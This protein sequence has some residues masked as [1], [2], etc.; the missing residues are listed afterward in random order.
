MIAPARHHLC[1]SSHTP[2]AMRPLVLALVAIW[3]LQSLQAQPVA[4]VRPPV[5]AL[6]AV[7]VPALKWQQ[8][9]EKY[10]DG[11]RSSLTERPNARG[12]VDQ[13][14][15]QRLA[16]EIYQW[17]R[18]DI[19]AAS[20]VEFM[21]PSG[22]AALN[23][24]DKGAA[25]S[26]IFGALTATVPNPNT[27]AGQPARIVGGDVYLLNANGILFGSGAQ[28]NVGALVASTLNVDNEDFLNGLTRSINGAQ[29][30]FWR[31]P[32]G[33]PATQEGSGFVEVQPGAE[34]RTPNGG[35]VFLFAEEVKQAGR[36]ETP[37]GQTVLAAGSEVYLQAP[38][39]E[40][41]YAAEHNAAVPALRG[42]LVE[43]GGE[44]GRV[45]Q[46]GEILSARGNTTLVGMAVNQ[47]GRISASTSVS[48]NGSVFLLARGKASA[49]SVAS[50]VF[51]RA[52]EGGSL[53]L[54]SS[55]RIEITPEASTATSSDSAGFTPSRIE[56]SARSISLQGAEP[57]AGS[58]GSGSG[59]GAS[60]VA[61]G[62][63][64][65]LRAET[66]PVYEVPDTPGSHALSLPK[67]DTPRF[68]ATASLSLGRGVSIDLSGTRDTEVSAGRHYVTT[69]LLGANDLK[70]APLQKDGLLY[71][72]KVTLDI[73]KDS[74]ILGSLQSYR[75]AVERSV[76]ER[77]SG[78]GSL[79]LE[80]AGLVQADAGS[81]LDL[82]G[83]R[84]RYTAAITQ[85]SQ[86]RGA[87]GLLY[88]LNEAPADQA[89]VGLSNAVYRHFGRWG[90]VRSFVLG[91]SL[92]LA[93]Y[94]E[95]QAAGS[96]RVAG[97]QL[98]LDGEMLARTLVGER[99]REGL[100][101]LAAPGRLQL[102]QAS[103]L[104]T[105]VQHT[106]LLGSSAASPATSG[107]GSWLD[108]GRLDASGFGRYALA[109][110]GDIVVE[111]ALRLAP[112]SQL[113]LFSRGAQGIRLAADVQSAGG[114]LSAQTVARPEQAGS[115]AGDIVVADGVRL[116]LAGR[117]VNQERDG[118]QPQAS[119]EGGSLRLNSGAGL[120]L[121]RDTVLDVSGGATVSGTGRV[122]AGAAG[123]I[124]LR[125]SM[126]G[127]QAQR[128]D[129]AGARLLGL[130]LNRGGSLSLRAAEVEIGGSASS[131]AE[132]GRLQ[133]GTE[134]FSRGGFE[135]LEIDGQRSL[136]LR[137]GSVISP[138]LLN[139][140]TSDQQLRLDP[141]SGQ[142]R[143]SGALLAELGAAPRE[144]E[145]ALRRPVHLSLLAS[146]QAAV[147][148][149]GR[150]LVEEGARIS[151]DPLASLNLR[152]AADL[153]MD[154]QLQAA[155]GQLSLS[156][157]GE[158][159]QQSQRLSLGR[160]AVI[161]VSG[162][163]LPLP[164][165]D[166]LLRGRVLDGGQVSL[167]AQSLDWAQGALI[168]ADGASATLD[169]TTARGPALPEGRQLLSS[170]AGRL[171]VDLFSNA[172]QD[173]L[174][175]GRF[176][177][178]AGSPE[179]AQGALAISVGR[180]SETVALAHRLLLQG[181]PAQAQPLAG[182]R[183]V[184]LGTELFSAGLA[185]LSLSSQDRLVLGGDLDLRLARRLVLDSPQ[186]LLEGNGQARLSAASV[187]L[188]SSSDARPG[189]S[190]P[191]RGTGRL[192][193]QARGPSLDVFGH[194][195][196]G[197][198]AALE[199]V[200]AGDMRL[201]AQSSADPAKANRGS[202]KAEAHI[203]LSAAQIYGSSASRF[204]LD[205][206][207][208]D[209]LITRPEGSTAT[210]TTP[211]SAGA[212]LSFKARDIVQDG[213]L[214]APLGQLSLQASERLLLTP[215]SQ[216]SVSGEGLTVFYGSTVGGEGWQYGGQA[217]KALPAKQIDLQAPRLELQAQGSAKA[218]LDLGGGGSLQA[219]EFVAGPGGSRDVFAESFDG[220]SGA[221]AIVPGETLAPLDNHM[222]QSGITALP[223]RELVLERALVLGE[224]VLAPGRYAV[225]P[226]R[227]ALLPGAVLV[228][229]E[230]ASD[231]P[232][233]AGT[234]QR[235]DNGALLAGARLAST[236]TDIVEGRLAGFVFTPSAT[237]RKSSEIR[238]LDLDAYLNAQAQ[239]EGLPRP[240]SVADAGHLNLSAQQLALAAQ[241]RL[242]A[243]DKG[244]AGS[245]AIAAEQMRVGASAAARPA[246]LPANTL[247]LAADELAAS[248]A[249]SLTL[250][251]LRAVDA[252]GQNL[253]DVRARQLDVEAG[254]RLQ[255]FADL[256]L[257]ARETVSLGQGV[258]LQAAAPA[259]RPA[260]Q[261][262]PA[263]LQIKGDGASLQLS[264]GG[265]ETLLRSESG[266]S[267]QGRLNLGQS[268]RLAGASLGLEAAGRLDLG[269]EAALQ[270]QALSLG[271]SRILIG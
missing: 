99:Q 86:L 5:P 102:G 85:P 130:G 221:F 111:Q 61:P 90:A 161:D 154:G 50:S 203:T 192:T 264:A 117:L 268:V 182:V 188:G 56:M 84:I 80:S 138:R 258:Q 168:R 175:A 134:F 201:H 200:S 212:V 116:E 109:S 198:M 172:T 8:S 257:L 113:S 20:K 65:R 157:S 141:N 58:G 255:G 112:R 119:A 167:S 147:G 230:A 237:A 240:A 32:L 63:S 165:S 23:R 159:A 122:V 214:R 70:D 217:L 228:R 105:G 125:S 215:R 43:V 148:G 95:G 213:L 180:R 54:G 123:A 251:A 208:Q 103:A 51:K 106:L 189:S 17:Q 153:R 53:V 40:K 83:G 266:A 174:L 160:N 204:E 171:S 35:R 236:G 115:Q 42:L 163:L 88:D 234:E 110:D 235:R 92:A 46:L 259:P 15:E 169:A 52:S 132:A 131:Q 68:D 100:D 48:E 57:S 4:G 9:R 7:P 25:P 67:P 24:V 271:A 267:P 226:A 108:L 129:I 238:S 256:K 27:A 244:Q 91:P 145:D 269:A 191:G 263:T 246:D 211:L 72:S 196:L 197:G 33:L 178:R 216:S 30:S 133:L 18:F 140:G 146:G 19:G 202:L 6:N 78:G 45:D 39:A 14:I 128:F 166:G 12:G 225:L 184:Q 22:G 66:V 185:D 37:G 224:Q 77:L 206:L 135:R 38:T 89:Y 155:G 76:Q 21:L 260:E 3:P 82:S 139:H 118:V 28:V 173:S 114:T 186:L 49:S 195:Q 156:Q 254:T 13:I 121:G 164:S 220:R 248:G 227:Y 149:S 136:S 11:A 142:A 34:I 96:L 233:A 41:L 177:A 101:K 120:A 270:V 71:R 152:A 127:D 158:T 218:R 193:L 1:V 60:I 126:V 245:L 75:D 69:E 26:A 194:Q 242:T 107:T 144:Q 207:G 47:M 223:G 79:M 62:A 29:R 252:K 36:I 124:E 199:L 190:A 243:A 229:P 10:E 73:R 176:E 249:G 253:A 97:S 81:R 179:R 205:A 93:G 104:A 2:R 262:S 94:E 31:D 151:L 170:H 261:G 183:T 64:V 162:R 209:L 137:A 55:S 232:V 87:D 16:R 44:A 210:P 143:A 150:L 181:G 231:T 265:G 250:G 98:R 187:A 74:K 247:W 241:L 222:A 59:P 239:R 219:L